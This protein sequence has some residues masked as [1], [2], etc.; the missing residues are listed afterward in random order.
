MHGVNHPLS[1]HLMY[2]AEN[3]VLTQ[4]GYDQKT[5]REHGH[6]C[7]KGKVVNIVYDFRK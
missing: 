3:K 2:I 7:Y 5:E 1:Y 6:H 4:S